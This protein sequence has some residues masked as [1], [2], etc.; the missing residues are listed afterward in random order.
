MPKPAEGCVHRLRLDEDTDAKLSA[1]IVTIAE[2]ASYDPLFHEVPQLGDGG[3]RVV[4]YTASLSGLQRILDA[5]CL[6]GQ[7]TNGSDDLD[8]LVQDVQS[9]PKENVVF[10]WECCSGCSQHTFGCQGEA[11]DSTLSL[12]KLLLDRGHMVMFSD[13]SLKALIRNWRRDLLGPNPFRQIG[14]CSGQLRLKFEPAVLKSCPSSQLVKVGELCDS[15]IAD[16]MAMGD[17]ILY[18]VVKQSAEEAKA[19]GIFELQQLTSAEAS[20]IEAGHGALTEVEKAGHVLLT[21]PS[22]GRL[23]TSAGHWK[24]VVNL[25]GVS[26]A[27]LLRTAEQYYGSTYSASLRDQLNSCPD[28]ASRTKVTQ[29]LAQSVVLQSP[30]CSQAP[31]YGPASAPA[32]L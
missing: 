23:L 30:P 26:D 4:T 1:V 14:S 10:N 29:T 18:T 12:T 16:I 11:L 8:E 3:S 2:G 17:T 27:A 22:G 7:A 13:F 24:E 15:G 32:M 28:K 5:L 21:Y 31:Y 6:A 9:V 20:F 25:R 19:Q